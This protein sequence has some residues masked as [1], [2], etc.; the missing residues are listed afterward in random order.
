MVLY[1]NVDC[2]TT[3][4]NEIKLVMSTR[5]EVS[6][7]AF[8]EVKPKRTAFALTDTQ[9]QVP[10]FELLTNL[11]NPNGRGIAVYIRSLLQ[12]AKQI[13]REEAEAE[14]K[15][16]FDEQMHQLN[17]IKELQQWM[18]AH[19]E[20]EK[21]KDT[22]DDDQDAAK[23]ILADLKNP[24]PSSS[25]DSIEVSAGATK[26]RPVQDIHPSNHSEQIKTVP[27]FYKSKEKR[28]HSKSSQAQRL[29]IG[30]Q[31]KGCQ[32]RQRVERD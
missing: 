29:K 6:V 24:K 10:G 18:V 21:E 12:A 9:I 7:F 20:A 13:E 2:I 5:H 1:S 26:S 16:L 11:S 14:D 31:K 22:T 8:T 15:R 4:M 17:Q 3:K 32:N 27:T 25:K 19:H 23:G 30:S 28:D